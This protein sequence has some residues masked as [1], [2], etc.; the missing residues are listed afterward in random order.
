MRRNERRVKLK[1]PAH[2]LTNHRW[3][4]SSLLLI[5]LISAAGACDL[6]FGSVGHSD[7]TG[8]LPE[9]PRASESL[10]PVQLQLHER[11]HRISVDFLPDQ[12]IV[13]PERRDERAQ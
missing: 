13:V 7:F 1:T 2:L 6:D 11:T 4:A 8:G 9:P 10:N 5:F 12:N 3:V